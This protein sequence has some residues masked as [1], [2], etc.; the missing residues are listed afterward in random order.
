MKKSIKKVNIL[1][2]YEKNLQKSCFWH[3]EKRNLIK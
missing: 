2:F 3:N 1:Y